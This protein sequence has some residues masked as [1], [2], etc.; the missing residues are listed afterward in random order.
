ML[1]LATMPLSRPGYRILKMRRK[2][3]PTNFWRMNQN[4]KPTV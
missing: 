3:E 1:G 2:E 4:I